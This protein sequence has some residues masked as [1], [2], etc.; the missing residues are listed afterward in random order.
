MCGDIAMTWMRSTKASVPN[1]ALGKTEEQDETSINRDRGL[2]FWAVTRHCDITAN[3]KGE[4]RRDV[5]LI[6]T[7]LCEKLRLGSL[8]GKWNECEWS[9]RTAA[10]GGGE[11]L[12][13]ESPNPGL[14][15][16]VVNNVRQWR[17]FGTSLKCTV[18]VCPTLNAADCRCPEA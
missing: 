7:Y 13:L 9:A 1:T 8:R 4:I 14:L 11:V 5:V 10:V 16:G 3:W 2:E 15:G 18:A 17:G 12:N 6:D